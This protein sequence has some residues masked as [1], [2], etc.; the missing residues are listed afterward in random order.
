RECLTSLIKR[1]HKPLSHKK[2]RAPMEPPEEFC[3]LCYTYPQKAGKT[4]GPGSATHGLPLIS[5]VIFQS[6]P[7]AVQ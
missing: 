5:G 1:L 6:F 3:R 4:P 2:M 7:K